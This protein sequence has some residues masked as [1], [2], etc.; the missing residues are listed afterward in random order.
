MN[1]TAEQKMKVLFIQPYADLSN[2]NYPPLGFLY[3]ASYMLA[4]SKHEVKIIDLRAKKTPIESRIAEIVDWKPDIVGITGLSIEWSGIK[5]V[6]KV[7]REELGAGVILVA[8]GAH[9][10]CFSRLVLEKTPVDYIVKNEGER[11]FLALTNALEKGNGARD[12]KGL[13]F[14]DNGSFID[15]GQ[16]EFI[17]NI[18]ELPFPAYHLL[19]MEV[20]FAD[21]RF[22]TTMNVKNRAIP[23]FTSRGCPFLC[24]YCVKMFGYNFRA[25]SPENVLAEI[26]WLVKTY[27]IQDLQIE[28]DSFNLNIDRAKAIMRG[29]VERDYHLWIIFCNGV[30]GDIVDQELVDLF[31]KAG[32]YR[33]SFGVETASPRV[34]K[35]TKRA[36]DF[37]KLEKSIE[38]TSR[39]G[40][41]TNGFFILG[42]PTET[43]EEMMTTIN[44]ALKSKLSTANFSLLKLFP[45]TPL[46]SEY[47]KE[48]PDFDDDSTFSYES[49]NKPNLSMVSDKRL[50]ELHRYA[51]IHF[52]LNPSR[53]WR[54]FRTSPNKIKLFTKN[55]QT[56]MSLIFKGR[57]KY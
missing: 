1:D 57:A 10:T 28:D 6:A 54:I 22:D 21:P 52:F 44:Y 3:L 39:A 46:A 16:G 37:K 24:R 25:R 40:L 19:D 8:G 55:F 9:A 41:S 17:E 23:I 11:T 31:K 13:V 51:Y 49:Y 50:L 47:L 2:T 32:V 53:I 56:V 36:L 20:Y 5:K 48:E 45:G 29:I 38:M 14:R 12:I 33:I 7:V 15:T 34:Q 27:Q 35:I 26:D 42:F 30:R 18:D 43:E 4:H